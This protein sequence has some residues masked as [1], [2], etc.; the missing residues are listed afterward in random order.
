MGSWPFL[1]KAAFGQTA[2]GEQKHPCECSAR[3]YTPVCKPA[4]G[5]D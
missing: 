3:V 4:S 2:V 1:H 5:I